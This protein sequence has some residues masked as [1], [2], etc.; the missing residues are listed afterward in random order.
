M[1]F[2]FPRQVGVEVAFHLHA[3]LQEELGVR[4]GGTL[5]PNP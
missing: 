4:V 1:L 5:N 3:N 2:I